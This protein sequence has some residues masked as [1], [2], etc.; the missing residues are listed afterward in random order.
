MIVEA[1]DENVAAR[2]AAWAFIEHELVGRPVGWTLHV[3]VIG[4]PLARHDGRS[5]CWT[6][7]VYIDTDQATLH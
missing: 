3:D 1:S 7:Y 6:V 5:R 2:L 4:P